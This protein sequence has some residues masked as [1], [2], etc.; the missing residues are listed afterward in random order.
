MRTRA[1]TINGLL[2]TSKL[3]SQ[4]A[5]YISKSHLHGEEYYVD[6]YIRQ[7]GASMRKT[8]GKGRELS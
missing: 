7:E 4:K 3:S 5:N 1:V 8:P 2:S 6:V